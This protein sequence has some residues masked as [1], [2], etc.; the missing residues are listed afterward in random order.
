LECH[1][2]LDSSLDQ[3]EE[4]IGEPPYF[5]LPL[6]TKWKKRLE[7]RFILDSSL[8]QVEE[9]IGVPPYFRFLS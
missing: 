7:C 4:K 1:L 2:I 8:D 9:K 6:M 3:V 5:R